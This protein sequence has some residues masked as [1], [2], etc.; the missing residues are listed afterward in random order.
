MV[1]AKATPSVTVD[2]IDEH[3][4]SDEAREEQARSSSLSNNDIIDDAPRTHAVHSR[5]DSQSIDDS[6][7]ISEPSANSDFKNAY[8]VFRALC[9]LSDRDIKN[10]A[11]SDPK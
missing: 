2:G 1:S 5:S 8:H 7:P 6:I 3:I 11:N 9:I 10:K 4:R